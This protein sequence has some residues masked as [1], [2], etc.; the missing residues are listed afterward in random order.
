MIVL[1]PYLL[2]CPQPLSLIIIDWNKI[3]ED[4]SSD[5]KE[6]DRVIGQFDMLLQEI[7]PYLE[8]FARKS[9]QALA[10]Q[11]SAEI[12]QPLFNFKRS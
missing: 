10:Y 12:N 7:I 5:K 11:Q 2:W 1:V 8:Y 6:E 3:H 9:T 4:L